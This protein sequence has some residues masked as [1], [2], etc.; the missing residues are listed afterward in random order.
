MNY[1]LSGI[2][3]GNRREAEHASIFFVRARGRVRIAGIQG[4]A[5]TERGRR[6]GRAGGYEPLFATLQ[7]DRRVHHWRCGHVGGGE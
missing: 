5:V 3:S 2:I 4:V 7:A 6:P 1:R